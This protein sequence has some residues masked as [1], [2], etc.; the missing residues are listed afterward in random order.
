M[1]SLSENER[2]WR[3]RAFPNALYISISVVFA[4]YEKIK[5]FM[6]IDAQMDPKNHKQIYIWAIRG[7]TFEVFGIVLRNAIFSTF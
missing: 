6:K 1:D 3:R 2:F 4:D 7:P 5:N